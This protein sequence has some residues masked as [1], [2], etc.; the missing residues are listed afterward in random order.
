MGED[1]SNVDVAWLHMELP[2]NLMMISG[3]F[4]FDQP[5]A[6]DRVRATL[7][8]RML[9][10]DRF[11]Q[12]VVEPRFGVGSPKWEFDPQFDIVNHVHR[13]ALPAPGDQATL[14]DL[15]SDMM[16]TPLDYSK[17]LW[18]FHLVE[19]YGEGCALVCRL[20]HC[21]ADGIALM[22]V[23]LSLTDDT[24][25]AQWTPP[26]EEE[27]RQ[28]SRNP[29]RLV[30]RPASAAFGATRQFSGSVWG[31]G[32]ELVTNPG[33]TLDLARQGADTTMALGRLLLMLPDR[34][35]ILKG[36]LGVPKR[37]AW[38]L[39]IPLPTVKAIG[40]ATGAT[41]NDVL[42]ACVA[43]A[44]RSYLLA[45]EQPVEGL[46][47]RGVIPVNLRPPDSEIELGNRFGL[48]FLS[49]P[50]GIADPFERLMELKRRMDDLKGT[51]EAVVAFGILNAIGMAPTDIEDLIVN[52]FGSKA[53]AVMTNVPGPRQQV[54][55]AGAPITQLMFW[56]PQ[57]GRLGIGV[58]ILSY[59]NEV[60]LGVAT[61]Q[62]LI[63]DPDRIVALFH[64][65]INALYELVNDVRPGEVVAPPA[66]LTAVKPTTR[67]AKA[68]PAEKLLV[69]DGIGPAF[70]NKLAAGGVTTLD[71]LARLS[72][73]D[74][75]SLM[76]A[77]DWRRPDYQGWIEQAQ[78]LVGDGSG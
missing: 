50:V 64:E 28:R 37:A 55:F 73:D 3:V 7:E 48:I 49:L 8:Q 25:D 67:A 63:P 60:L 62:G 72:P 41:V 71:D 2:N 68:V 27:E 14:Q 44:L 51:P 23:L 56:V 45:R 31:E 17:P 40:Q 61:D 54:Y 18:Q 46:N 58:S 12:K 30:T 43:G 36:P 1:L 19:G 75:A 5:L 38:S 52:I 9:I 78:K 13:I 34:K 69:I 6:F 77:P 32:K 26:E 29:F 24:P 76:Q 35:T 22:R 4:I 33:H 10:F 66:P 21:I 20:H 70:A 47:V 74:L 39:P 59:N 53:T 16:A 65:E 57:S 15:V 42:L 11:R